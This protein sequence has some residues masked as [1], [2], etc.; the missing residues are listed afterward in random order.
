MTD[1]E[2]V[3]EEYPKA[4]IHAHGREIWIFSSDYETYKASGYDPTTRK[5]LSAT[6]IYEGPWEDVAD[7]SVWEQTVAPV[8]RNAAMKL[9]GQKLL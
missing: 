1:K 7:E 2:F 8:W 3:Q 4:E 5:V 9:R 6:F